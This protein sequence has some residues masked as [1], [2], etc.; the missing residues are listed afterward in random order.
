MKI[1]LRTVK[2]AVGAT[3]AILIAEWWGLEYAV[4]AGLITVLS[5]QNTKKGSIQLAIQRVYSTIIA[6]TISAIFFLLLGFN[7]IAFGFYLLVFIPIAVRLKVTD[8]IVVS[9]V[10]V[11]HILVEQSL[12][13]FWFT[14]EMLL[15]AV[16]AGIGILLNL[17]MPKM[18]TELK[19]Q[20]QK[21]ESVMRQIFFCF[22][23]DLKR[24][25]VYLDEKKL[26]KQLA[27]YLTEANAQSKRHF[28]NQLF[29]DSRYY[30]KYI[31]M[32]TVQLRVIRQMNLSVRQISILTDHAGK[33]A[34]LVEKTALSL[35]EQ[36]PAEDL[37]A[38]VN[39]MLADFRKSD[40]P[41]TREE[42]EGRALLF[43]FLGDL[44]YLLELKRDFTK[45]FAEDK[46]LVKINAS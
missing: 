10:L 9:S 2:T 28:D 6:L 38:D 17:Y 3:L 34:S 29:A 45:Q 39:V 32:R 16:G 14:N 8:G 23:Q 30:I 31:D 41:K 37:I 12:S 18:D 40:L 25:P 36:N 11:T 1:G 21:I 4:S 22:A 42:F 26:I 15:M 35:S 20:R 43:Q 19:V 33:M 44:R 13:L 7:A 5:I 46:E 27:E 24:E